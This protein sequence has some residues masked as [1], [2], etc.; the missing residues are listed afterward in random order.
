MSDAPPTT[1]PQALTKP[2][3]TWD[4]LCHITALAGFLIP[5]GNIIGPLV[6]WLIK[7]DQMPSV[8]QHGKESVNFQISM[9]IYYIVC[10]VLF[11]VAIGVFLLP[12]V[13]LANLILTIVATIKASNGEFYSYPA[14]IRF[15]K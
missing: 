15:I 12:I 14:T 1:P 4:I 7:K 6:V 10:L 13:L 2:D 9:T 11:L 3:R 5:F 8:D